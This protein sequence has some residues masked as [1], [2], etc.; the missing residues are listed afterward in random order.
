VYLGNTGITL[1]LLSPISHFG[2][3]DRHGG[4]APGATTAE[5]MLDSSIC[6]LRAYDD[7]ADDA[8][9]DNCADEDA[10]HES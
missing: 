7:A 1:K 5:A 9:I 3:K 10:G 4:W 8:P 2:T 6:G